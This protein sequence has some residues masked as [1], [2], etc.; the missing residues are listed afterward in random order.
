MV[1]Y[2]ARPTWCCVQCLAFM[3]VFTGLGPHDG[4]HRARPAWCLLQ[5]SAPMIMLQGSA[6]MMFFLVLTSMRLVLERKTCF[7]I[8]FWGFRGDVLPNLLIECWRAKGCPIFCSIVEGGNA[9]H[10]FWWLKG[11]M[12]P[13]FLFDRW[14]GYAAQCFDWP[15]KGEMLPNFLFDPLPDVLFG[16]LRLKCCPIFC[17]IVDG[18]HAAQFS[19]WLLQRETLPNFWFGR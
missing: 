13:N 10:F 18:W 12:L 19:F 11:E 5:G 16:S 14:R 8:S 4:M 6:Y 7:S 15:L 1:F 2:S 17:L 3:V 9:A